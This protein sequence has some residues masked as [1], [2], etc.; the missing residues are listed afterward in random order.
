MI[1]IGG[2]ITDRGNQFL[3]EVKEE[4]EKYLQ[5]RFIIIVRLNLHKTVIVQE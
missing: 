2:G 5:K 3:K 1:V 4:V